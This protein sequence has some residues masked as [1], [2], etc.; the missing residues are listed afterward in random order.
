MQ[1][2]HIKCEIG[3]CQ[4]EYI[5]LLTGRECIHNEQVTAMQSG[6]VA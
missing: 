4:K 2:T 3:V 5:G 1:Y 6:Y